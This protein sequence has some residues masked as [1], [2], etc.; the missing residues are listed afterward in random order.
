[1]RGVLEPLKVM[2]AKWSTL[3]LEIADWADVSAGQEHSTG[4]EAGATREGNQP[5]VSAPPEG[6][7][8]CSRIHVPN[9]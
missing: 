9:R 8:T 5:D 1:L 6:K 3:S 7:N 4:A 2:Q